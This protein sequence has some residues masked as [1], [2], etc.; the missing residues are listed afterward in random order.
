MKQFI[1][2]HETPHERPRDWTLLV[3]RTSS[4][5]PTTRVNDNGAAAAAEVDA[6]DNDNRG[7]KDGVDIETVL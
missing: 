3:Q 5:K 2:A 4:I 6:N 7:A 1:G